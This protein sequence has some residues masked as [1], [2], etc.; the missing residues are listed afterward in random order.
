[1]ENV[2]APL[3]HMAARRLRKASKRPAPAL[4]CDR[5]T[6]LKNLL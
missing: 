3:G 2:N 5:A 4:A 1:M 6:P